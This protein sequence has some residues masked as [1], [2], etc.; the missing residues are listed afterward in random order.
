MGPRYVAKK[1]SRGCVMLTF[2]FP[3][4]W[5]AYVSKAMAGAG[6]GAERRFCRYSRYRQ[7]I[8]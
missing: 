1:G 7:R 4:M 8:T 5:S 3:L 6:T 2:Q